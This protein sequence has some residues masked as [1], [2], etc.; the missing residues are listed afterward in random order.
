VTLAGTRAEADTQVRAVAAFAP[1]TDL[2]SD[3]ERRGGLSVS[4]K[5]LFNVDSTN[6]T[7]EVRAVLKENSPLTYV[8]PGLPPFLIL[9]GSADKTVPIGQS[10][11]FVKALNAAGVDAT[12]IAIPEGQHRI[13][14]WTKFDPAW[15]GKLITWL[16]EKLATK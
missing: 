2:V 10:E 8:R 9:N 14:D 1:P 6:L 3:N 11:N 16:N 12:L 5:N 4:M 15:Q 13:A 7:D